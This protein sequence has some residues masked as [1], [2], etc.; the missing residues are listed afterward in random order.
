MAVAMT[1]VFVV[2][3]LRAQLETE[4]KKREVMEKEKEQ[5]EREKV[6]LMM[7]L[8]LFEEQTLKAERGLNVLQDHDT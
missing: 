4:K 1:S 5:M 3:H 6:E 7:R 8:K 2:C